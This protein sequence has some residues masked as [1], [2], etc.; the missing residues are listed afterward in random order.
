M[1]D[2][3]FYQLYDRRPEYEKLREQKENMLNRLFENGKIDEP[4]N[5]VV[6]SKR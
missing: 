4:E 5:V 6:I 2:K 1:P 3:A